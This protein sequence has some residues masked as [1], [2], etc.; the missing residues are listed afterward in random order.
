MPKDWT[1]ETVLDVARSYHPAAVLL[2]AAELDVFSTLA[3]RA[4]T[5]E[6]LAASLK[7]D[8]RAV[9][10]LADALAALGFLEKRDG[11]YSLAPGVLETLTED[12]PAC[13]LPMLRHQANCLRSWADLAAVVKTG[14]LPDHHRAE[15]C[16]PSTCLLGRRVAG[17][18]ASQ[19]CVRISSDPGSLTRCSSRVSGRWTRSFGRRRSD[20]AQLLAAP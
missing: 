1:S 14:R 16:S 9:N 18:S 12:G 6:E 19:N 20:Q 15:P 10:I 3:K 7:G 5:A 8:R 2:A 4:M 13:V 17:H 11:T